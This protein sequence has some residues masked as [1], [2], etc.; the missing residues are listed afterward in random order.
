MINDRLRI[1]CLDI[2]GG[3]GGSSR[4]LYHSI[5]HLPRNQTAVEVWCKKKGPV[6]DAY[7]RLGVS[8]RVE[9]LMP[10]L[11]SLPRT[12]RNLFFYCRYAYNFMAARPFLN[13]LADADGRFDC[14]H[15]NHEG[16]FL[17]AKW[18]R[19]RAGIPF[20]M[21]LRTRPHNS[22]FS[23]IQ[24]KVISEVIDKV[25]F[26]TRNEADHFK[27]LGG[28]CDGVVIHNITEP[29]KQKSL[30]K[31]ERFSRPFSIVSL[32]NFS[33]ERGTDRLFEI[34]KT[35]S[36]MGVNGVRFI[37]AGNM[38]AKEK[39]P[40]SLG[41]YL[42]RGYSFA[43]FVTQSE[44]SESFEF[45]GHVP[46]PERVM[47]RGDALIKPARG[48]NPWGRDVIEALSLGKP[49]F[50]TGY[51]DTFVKHGQTGFL[52]SVYDPKTIAR[53]IVWSMNNRD[54]F[55]N[56]GRQAVRLVGKLCAGPKRAADLINVWR[57]L[58]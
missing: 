30:E 37:V 46:D 48:M 21:H 54:A 16:L 25:V 58:V 42:K 55:N 3:Y 50:A 20:T 1:L 6:Q 7:R 23:R 10:T 43:E 33:P 38:R 31:E 15:F 53:D 5:K 41:R 34:A 14:I 56:M 17:L 57:S 35:L 44:L 29:Y 13:R 8:C 47:M 2:E 40:G 27:R 28:Y 4:S 24:M 52:Y 32:S 39:V 12:T 51:D 49:V 22:F 9:P 26:I 18:L 45:L 11:S 36:E 19:P